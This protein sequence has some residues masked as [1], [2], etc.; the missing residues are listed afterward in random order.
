[1]RDL[2]ATGFYTTLEGT[3]DLQYIG[4]TPQFGF[5]GP[6]KEVLEYLKLQ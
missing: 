4:N 6:P 3:K 2:T 5:K 1:M